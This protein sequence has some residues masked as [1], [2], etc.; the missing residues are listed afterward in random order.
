M[1]QTG[2][3]FSE[4]LKAGVMKFKKTCRGSGRLFWDRQE[5]SLPFP[6]IFIVKEGKI[7]Y[8]KENLF[9]YASSVELE[10]GCL[11]SCMLVL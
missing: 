4:R 10:L 9:F 5:G 2:N 3:Q 7:F 11:L 6:I 1:S 8:K